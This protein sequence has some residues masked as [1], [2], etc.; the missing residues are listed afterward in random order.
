[1]D[2]ENFERKKHFIFVTIHSASDK[3]VFLKHDR[4]AYHGKWAR[5]GESHEG[6]NANR[7]FKLEFLGLYLPLM[8]FLSLGALNRG[9]ECSIEK[10]SAQS[11]KRESE[12]NWGSS[13]ER[14]N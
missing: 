13:R 1:M 9:R 10:K 11:R 3:T 8:L 4:R 6:Q 2:K 14:K 12:G 5:D 7:L